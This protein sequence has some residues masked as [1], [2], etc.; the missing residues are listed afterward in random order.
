MEEGLEQYRELES[1]AICETM[2]DLRDFPLIIRDELKGRGIT[3]KAFAQMVGASE[4]AVSRWLT[5]VSAFR[6][7][8]VQRLAG[9]LGYEA[10]M[11]LRSRP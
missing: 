9:A 11:V 6:P 4:P 3:Q 10:V 7:E 5:Q 8:T 1:G 2:I